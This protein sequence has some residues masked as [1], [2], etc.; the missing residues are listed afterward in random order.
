VHEAATRALDLRTL[1]PQ[2]R[3][4]AWAEPPF[5]EDAHAGTVLPCLL[6][7]SRRP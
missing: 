1:V 6:G 3:A 7:T 5:C 4:T 2:L